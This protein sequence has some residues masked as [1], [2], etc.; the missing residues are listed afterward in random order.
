MKKT[1]LI[2]QSPSAGNLQL[3]S[4]LMMETSEIFP[5]KK[6]EIKNTKMIAIII[7][8]QHCARS[9]SKCN[10]TRKCKMC[11]WGKKKGDLSVFPDL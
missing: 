7:I 2:L 6:R 9:S 4:Q 3:T 1:F 10:K 8:I 11:H 5:Q